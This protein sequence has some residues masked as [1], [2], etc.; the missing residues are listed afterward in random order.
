MHRSRALFDK[1]CRAAIVLTVVAVLMNKV[2]HVGSAGF[3]VT[4]C[5]FVLLIL[6]DFGGQP[7]QRFLAYA[8]AGIA[9]MV[10]IVIGALVAPTCRSRWA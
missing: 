9:G 5:V 2:I 7:V 1:A 10:L 6:A 3:F 4:F 8:G